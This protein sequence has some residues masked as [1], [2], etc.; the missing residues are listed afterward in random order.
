MNKVTRTS[1]LAIPKV[2]TGALPASAKVYSSPEGHP[3]LAVP[4]REIALDETSGESLPS[5]SEAVGQRKTFRVYDPSGPYTDSEA[6]IDVAK[7]LP[8]IRE[9]WVEER[10]GVERYE[11]RAVR[12]EDNGNVS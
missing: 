10:G 8:R 12:P 3:D 6:L 11:G 2:T 9:A 7:G 1:E 5:S 4:F